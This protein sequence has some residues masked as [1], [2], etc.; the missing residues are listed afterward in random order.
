MLDKQGGPKTL[1]H[2]DSY[3]LDRLISSSCY[4][5]SS[6]EVYLAFMNLFHCRSTFGLMGGFFGLNLVSVFPGFI[7]Y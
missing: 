5:L 7:Y 3:F 6:S 4:R 1:V 2:R